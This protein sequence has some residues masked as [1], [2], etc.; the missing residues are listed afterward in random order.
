MPTAHGYRRFFAHYLRRRVTIS[1]STTSVIL[2][3]DQPARY[4]D[5]ILVKTV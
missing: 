5:T 2:N 4:T 1:L 3:N